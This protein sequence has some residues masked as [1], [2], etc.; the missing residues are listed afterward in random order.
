MEYTAVIRHV[1]LLCVGNS[2]L[3]IT[4]A[5]GGVKKK[6]LKM[7]QIRHFSWFQDIEF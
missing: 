3:I 4:K 5:P 7:A 6:V 1:Q 2:V